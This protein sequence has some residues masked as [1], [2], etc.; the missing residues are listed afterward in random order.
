MRNERNSARQT[1]EAKA[2]VNA[3]GPWVNDIVNR[4]AG[5]NSKRSVRLVKGSHIITP[6]FWQGDHAYLVQNHDKRVIFINPYEGDK[7]LIGTT[8]IPYDARVEDVV[9]DES[10]ITYLIEAVN[11]YFT[12]PLQRSDVI[13]SFAG[14]RPL[15]DDGQGNPSAVTR[16]YVFDLEDR[17]GL[18]LLNVFGGKITTFRKLAEHALHKLTPYFPNAG[19]DWTQAAHLPGGGLPE[20][21]PGQ[22]MGQLKQ[23]CPF[24]TPAMQGH[25]TRLYGT[26]AFEILRDVR[27]LADLGENFGGG[28]FEAELRY[29]VEHEWAETAAD[30]LERRTKYGLKLNPEQKRAVATWLER[31]MTIA[32]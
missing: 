19:P 26:L 16:D 24:L 27:S 7:A 6:K 11:R 25:F 29:L 17:D 31:Q 20:A 1:V 12:T 5:G 32:A 9:A 8:D 28:L 14:V 2:V 10:E 22:F 30:V 4:V 23:R 3:G 15:F 21:D 18:P 13:E